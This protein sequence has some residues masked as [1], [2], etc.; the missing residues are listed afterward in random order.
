[1]RGEVGEVGGPVGPR[2]GSRV[3]SARHLKNLRFSEGFSGGVGPCRTH[4]EDGTLTRWK[5][6]VPQIQAMGFSPQP[7]VGKKDLPA[8][9]Q[10]GSQPHPSKNRKAASSRPRLQRRRSLLQR[11]PRT[12]VDT[13]PLAPVHVSSESHRHLACS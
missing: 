8:T 10:N 9:S 12:H 5:E 11:R 7:K 6:P 4:R 1:M 3:G 2:S 13:R